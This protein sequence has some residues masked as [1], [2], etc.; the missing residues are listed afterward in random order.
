VKYFKELTTGV[1]IKAPTMPAGKWW[2]EATEHEYNAYRARVVRVT[3]NLEKA[4]AYK[5]R[6]LKT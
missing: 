3:G 1:V 5:A 2:R 6:L 4:V